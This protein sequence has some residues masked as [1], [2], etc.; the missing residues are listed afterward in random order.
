M[1]TLTAD[2]P[3]L[4]EHCPHKL[5]SSCRLTSTPLC[6]ACADIRPHSSTYRVYIDG[7]GFVY[8][9]T[10]WQSYCWFCKSEFS[11]HRN[12][13]IAQSLTKI[14]FWDARVAASG[15]ST[16]ETRI[17][18]E[19]EQSEFV[20][21]WNEFHQGYR[22]IQTPEGSEEIVPIEAESLS[23]ADPGHL[24]RTLEEIHSGRQALLESDRQ[25]REAARPLPMDTPYT[26][27]EDQLNEMLNEASDDEASPDMLMDGATVTARIEAGQPAVD[28]GDQQ[29]VGASDP[30]SNPAADSTPVSNPDA[31]SHDRLDRDFT[32]IQR[33]V[34]AAQHARDQAGAAL[35]YRELLLRESQERMRRIGRQQHR[36]GNYTRTFGTREDVQ[37]DDYVSPITNMFRRQVEWDRN[38]TIVRAN[39]GVIA[40]GNVPTESSPSTQSAAQGWRDTR[41]LPPN[42]WANV[43]PHDT[44]AARR[45]RRWTQAPPTLSNVIDPNRIR[46]PENPSQETTPTP[47]VTQSSPGAT[48]NIREYYRQR[49]E[50]QLQRHDA[51]RNAYSERT[52]DGPSESRDGF[53]PFTESR[54]F[55][56]SAGTD[57]PRQAPFNLLDAL[58][59]ADYHLQQTEN[60]GPPRMSPEEISPHTQRATR[61]RVRRPG[62]EARQFI[63]LDGD[64][65]PEAQEDKEMTVVLDCK[66]CLSLKADTVC[67][68][69]G[70]LCMCHWCADQWIPVRADDVTRALKKDAKCP[71]CKTVV[72][73]RQKVFVC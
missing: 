66:I 68:P 41:T 32:A 27:I 37:A 44:S 33:V 56:P 36:M 60:H 11:Q 6:C 12:T 1:G 49:L 30:S 67:F 28:V 21:R 24:P 7:V 26:S 62:I 43:P 17:P 42:I 22:T 52:T 54:S 23:E 45:A 35:Q 46:D 34:E 8:R 14:G 38:N 50:A 31:E 58:Q 18:E 73:R 13:R 29:L 64:N 69:C 55:P 51:R 40:Q 70:H 5:P 61:M 47:Q 4:N 71:V 10:R 65:R 63:G 53:A 20:H 15:L 25:R 2:C 72:K 59:H 16:S 48:Q 57:P 3:R 39:A 19:P 9:G